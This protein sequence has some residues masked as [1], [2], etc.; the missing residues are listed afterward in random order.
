[1]SL[2][3]TQIQNL[4][5]KANLDK[6]ELRP[7]RY[8]ALD[9][10][11][12]ETGRAGGILSPELI[13]KAKKSIGSVI[14]T[15]VYDFDSGV[16]ISNARTLTIADDENTSRMVD[17]TFKT[18]SW[19]FTMVPTL[20]HNNEMGY[21]ADFQQKF[22]KYLYKL[23]AE[24]DSEALAA[25]A[26]AKNRVYNDPLNY[27]V[28]GNDLIAGWKDRENV[29]GDLNP[30]FAANDHYNNIHI[31]GNGGIESMVRKM[32][33]KGLYNEVNK[34]L[35]YSDKTFHFTSRLGNASGQFGNAYA[36]Q[37]GS[38]GMLFR[39]EREALAGTK[40][41]DGHEWGI[42]NLPMLN[43]PVGTYFYQSVGDF[44][45]IAGAASADM[46]RVMKEHFGF[47]V[48]VAFVTVYNSDLDTIANP[49]IKTTI[50]KEVESDYT[51]IMVANPTANPVNTK[52]VT[53]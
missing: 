6:N 50:N 51:K 44:S 12:S 4:R 13:K 28:V 47:A 30:I 37:E 15:P 40:M 3:N 14:Q 35:E 49:V 5:A 21:N 43:I 29:L 41:A 26:T 10:F 46:D 2:L 36:V 9:F 7:S 42:E 27:N 24:L 8:G 33:E 45:G 23:G 53:P 52:E 22:L 38:V 32:A 16:T 25:L 18:Y 1:M 34:A 31:V 39:F 17:I 20:Y 11:A 19:G 48:D